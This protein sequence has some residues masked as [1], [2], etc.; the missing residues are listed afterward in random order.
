MHSKSC[1]SC[2][3][4]TNSSQLADS[5]KKEFPTP[6]GFKGS[7]EQWNMF[8]SAGKEDLDEGI[9]TL[10]VKWALD[11]IETSAFGKH[12]MS[13]TES[14]PKDCTAGNWLQGLL[15]LHSSLMS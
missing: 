8:Q 11:S 4:E 7:Q 15:A 1:K 9:I 14:R 13:A 5:I 2:P 12:S 6:P 10:E 3:E